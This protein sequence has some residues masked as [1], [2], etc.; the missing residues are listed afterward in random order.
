MNQK[1]LIVLL[2]IAIFAVGGTILFMLSRFT[3]TGLATGASATAESSLETPVEETPKAKLSLKF[4][5][6]EEVVPEKLIIDDTEVTPNSIIEIG[7]LTKGN[8]RL[9][10]IVNGL[11]FEKDFY[12]E[13]EDIT[14]KIAKPV[15]TF[16]A[17]FSEKTGEPISNVTIYVDGENKCTT[18]ADGTCSFFA[19][20]GNHTFRIQGEGILLEEIKNI[21]RSLSSFTF[22][23][24]RKL[25]IS[26]SVVDEIT[27]EPV[28][29]AEIYI[30]GS[31]KGRTDP[32]GSYSVSFVE[33][34]TH[35]LEVK[36]GNIS[37]STTIYVTPEN[38]AFQISI[39]LPRT[40]TIV[41][42]DKETQLPVNG[43][44][45][46]IRNEETGETIKSLFKTT[47]EGKTKLANVLPGEYRLEVDVPTDLYKTD[48]KPTAYITITGEESE[49][50]VE[51]EMPHP[52]FRG[53]LSCKDRCLF[54]PDCCYVTLTNKSWQKGI[55]T[56]DTTLQLFVLRKAENGEYEIISTEQ[57]KFGRIAPGQEVKAI[58]GEG[59][60]NEEG[61]RVRGLDCLLPET[62]VAVVF[63][64]W[65]WTPQN[66]KPIGSITIPESELAKITKKVIKYC[67]QNPSVCA[68]AIKYIAGILVTPT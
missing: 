40:I 29:D 26:I 8:H 57:Y 56:E 50:E 52:R 51:V 14:I 32:A 47:D 44:Y 6:G 35:V 54:A 28:E 43:F 21:S 45:V 42:K 9:I 31:Y 63:E 7:D 12:F 23:V 61:I 20:P 53:S 37:D 13:G 27:K 46:E 59:C 25:S 65:R 62:V 11:E 55:T 48:Y 16:V 15:Q 19:K 4:D 34:G 38:T 41:V 5:T 24:T 22:K 66:A 36:K 68:N 64:G 17:V 18:Q 60:E 33:E 10:I 3:P 39:K 2:L 30:D 49:I 58:K 1:M 67:E